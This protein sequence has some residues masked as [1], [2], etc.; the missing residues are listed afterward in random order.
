[1]RGCIPTQGPPSF[2]SRPLLRRKH[3]ENTSQ[4]DTAASPSKSYP[5]RVRASQRS[6]AGESAE[7]GEVRT[8]LESWRQ[9]EAQAQQSPQGG[10]SGPIIDTPSLDLSKTE[11]ERQR[12]VERA[13]R[14]VDAA[15]KK[16]EG[17]LTH[18]PNLPSARLRRK[19]SQRPWHASAFPSRALLD[20]TGQLRYLS[21]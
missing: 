19:V 18:I 9:E 6:A 7:L 21:A 14:L 11:Q 13:L 20:V 12:E 4:R 16:A 8:V 2:S 3:H 5:S 17:Q 15:M 10:A 1:M